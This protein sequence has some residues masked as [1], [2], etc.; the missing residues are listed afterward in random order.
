MSKRLTASVL[1][2]LAI[3]A[4]THAEESTSLPITV[5]AT[6]FTEPT[7]SVLAPVNIITRKDI[8]QLHARSLTDV[9]NT[10]PG[11][12]VTSY[13]GRGQQSS[14]FVRGAT[15]AETLVL[16]DGVRVN[17]ATMGGFDFS[18][19]PLNQVE[20]V[21]FIR[22]ARATVYGADAI[23]GVVNIITRGT[24]GDR[25]TTLNGSAGSKGYRNTNAATSFDINDEQHLKLSAGYESEDGYNVHPVIDD[26]DGSFVNAGEKNGFLG[27]NAMIDYQN[28][29]NANTKLFS[30]VHWS[31]NIAESDGSSS[32]Y[33]D[34]IT[35]DLVPAVYEKDE[36]WNQNVVYQLGS[37][38][39]QGRYQSELMTSFIDNISY[40]YPTTSDR[41]NPESTYDTNQYQANWSNSYQIN[42]AITL[43]GGV[44]WR[45]DILLSDSHSSD[46]SYFNDDHGRNN[47][48]VYLLTQANWNDI[49][50][51]L[52][53]RVDENQQYGSY[54]TWQTG[55][56]WSFVPGYRVSAR[57]GTAFRAPTFNDLYYPTDSWGYYGNP[58]LSP[59]TSR[60]SEVALEGLS[61]GINW[62]VTAYRNDIRNMIQWGNS[63]PENKDHA[64][65]DGLELEA[66]FLTGLLQ[67]KV[68]ADFMNPVD[69]KSG[70]QLN[71]RARNTYKWTGSVN[72]DK[73]D[74]S[75]T[76]NYQSSR[77]SGNTKLLPYTVWN[78]GL[79]YRV[80]K[81]LHVG[82]RIDNL[83]DKDYVLIS[84]YKPAGQN[85]YLDASYQF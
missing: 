76:A 37:K 63:T 85:F 8:E 57:Y 61:S 65:I 45:R 81:Q 9:M 50:G 47:T 29:L 84:G 2:A 21:E 4:P 31:R 68:S 82:G 75:L 48:G 30:S 12:Q 46:G 34:W 13:G 78:A 71:Y 32:S 43:G 59:E 5:T 79:G 70:A 22:G 52:S 33:N 19:V 72:W 53:G 3:A 77:Y 11:I 66:Q 14:G 60:N 67:H 51:E 41:Y 10:L 28:D 80:T 25:K 36:T 40:Y 69:K 39:R 64:Q 18:S 6:R 15:S 42:D 83:F 17:S 1:S 73:W 74:S 38:Y 62:R 24:Q 58:D 55:L 49:T 26:L 20:R 27:R 44:D 23:G 16:M 54:D 56:G 7:A 35:G